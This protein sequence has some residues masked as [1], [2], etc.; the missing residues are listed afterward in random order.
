MAS[1][2]ALFT[3]I[4]LVVL[5]QT[6]QSAPSDCFCT[7][8]FRPLCA[9]DGV[10]YANEC[11]FHCEA[12][13]NAALEISH[14]GECAEGP[15]AKIDVTIGN[16]DEEDDCFCTREYNPVCGS[17][18]KTYGNEC[19]LECEVKKDAELRLARYGTCEDDE[20]NHE[21][22]RV[23]SSESDLP[24]DEEEPCVC[25]ME[26]DPQ[27]GSD[28]VTYGNPCTFQCELKKK[29]DLYVLHAGSCDEQLAADE[30]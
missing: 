14:F 9:S 13:R 20:P 5:V 27:C 22:N 6:I 15:A 7:R 30:E 26:F 11:E 12:V 28:G 17:D 24:V 18:D 3:A 8:E 2:I 1:K 23:S 25:T 16:D 29:S 19:L 21:D 4:V 10:T